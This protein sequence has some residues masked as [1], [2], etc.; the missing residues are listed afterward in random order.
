MVSYK[1][2][3]DAHCPICTSFVSMLK[4]KV[5]LAKISF[6][7]TTS[8]TKDFR[9]DISTGKVVYGQDAINELAQAF[10]AILNYFW[11]LPQGFKK[12]ALNMVY[13]AGS[14]ARTVIKK[15]T[16]CGCGKK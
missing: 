12:P 2:Y 5:D 8:N 4:T 14:V 15:A 7:P 1:L 3:Y 16:G 6:L 11:M 9:L 13:K 10:P